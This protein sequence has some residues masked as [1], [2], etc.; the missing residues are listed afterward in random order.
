MI[1][2]NSNKKLLLVIFVLLLILLTG[3][4]NNNE[5]SNISKYDLFTDLK[6]EGPEYNY[7][8]INAKI[9]VDDKSSIT[10]RQGKAKFTVLNKKY[11]IK[12]N[13]YFDNIKENT[14]I[15]ENTTLNLV[16]PQPSKMNYDL[17]YNVLFWKGTVNYRW[18]VEPFKVFFDFSKAPND[19]TSQEKDDYITQCMNEIKE[20]SVLENMSINR[21]T[22]SSKSNITVW[23]MSDTEYFNKFPQ[24]DTGIAGRGGPIE[25]LNGYVIK[26][27]IW[28]RESNADQKGVYI[29]EMGHVLGFHHPSN[30]YSTNSVMSYDDTIQANGLTSLDKLLLKLKMSISPMV[31][32]N[33]NNTT[34][35]NT[36]KSWSVPIKVK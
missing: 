27:A 11:D 34:N 31:Q 3:C 19:I 1:I 8:L 14:Y 33:P 28:V 30:L 13:T 6:I 4:S 17:F 18:K 5:T 20:W 2:N 26:G 32:Y 29:H 36:K 21:T 24:D 35:I 15:K 25:S 10:N 7:P 9:T 23:V 16:M 12:A 22:E